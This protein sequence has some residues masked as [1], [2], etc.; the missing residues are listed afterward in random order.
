MSAAS[1]AHP[2]FELSRELIARAS[3]TPDD[4]GCQSLLAGR[5]AA[6]GFSVEPLA[7]GDVNNLWARRGTT[8]PLFCFAGHTD[9]VP[10]GPLGAWRT[11]PFEPSVV[12][13]ELVGRGACDMKCAIA[14]MVVACERFLARHPEPAGSIAFLLTSDEEGPAVDGSV[15]VVEHLRARGEHLDFC[16]IGEPTSVDAVGDMLKNGRRGSLSGKLVIKG[17]QGHIAY[18]H[19]A[20]N[21]VHLMAPALAEL[22]A[23]RWDEGNEDFQPTAWQVS[24]IHAGTGAG[25]II[26]GSV[27]I[28]F[29]FRF[30]PTSTAASLRERL[31]SILHRHGL[32]FDLHW[33]LGGE[34]FHTGRGRLVDVAVKSIQAV[35]GRQPEVSTTGGTSDGRFIKDICGELIEFGAR[36]ATA[37]AVDERVS[38]ETPALL[39]AIYEGM[40]DRLLAP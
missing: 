21:P 9:V 11:P 1:L 19:L 26:P 15:R 5:L 39:A 18:P 38:V 23:T 35:T 2:A 24:N 30:A 6:A 8:G 27:E 10:T 25:N 36:N 17:K 34:P 20:A 28:Q 3:V 37:H 40:L 14:A 4:A 16:V 7:W 13:G 32:A 31:E 22:T 33:T 12:D 29:N